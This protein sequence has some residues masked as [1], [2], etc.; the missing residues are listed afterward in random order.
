[1][2]V[3]YVPKKTVVNPFK[4]LRTTI[5]QDESFFCDAT[6]SNAGTFWTLVLNRFTDMKDELKSFITRAMVIP[7]GSS[8]N[9]RS[10]R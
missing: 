3:N 8:S 1:M 6:T 9:E 5:L 7:L 2:H 4:E 10:F